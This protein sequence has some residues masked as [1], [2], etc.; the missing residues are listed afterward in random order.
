MFLTAISKKTKTFTS[1]KSQALYQDRA[2]CFEEK[3]NWWNKPGGNDD[4]KQMEGMNLCL[5]VNTV[6]GDRAEGRARGKSRAG[7]A[8]LVSRCQKCHRNDKVAVVLLLKCL[9]PIRNDARRPVGGGMTR[10]PDG[11]SAEGNG[12]YPFAWRIVPAGG[13]G[14]RFV[15]FWTASL[16]SLVTDG[17][18]HLDHMQVPSGRRRSCF[19]MTHRR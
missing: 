1:V 9:R 19:S 18:F 8:H 3:G 6:H 15:T 17:R 14:F 13:S 11:P 4:K 10:R 16:K 5:R 12:R 2:L 7:W